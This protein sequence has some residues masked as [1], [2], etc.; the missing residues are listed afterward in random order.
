MPEA[1][2]FEA[3]NAGQVSVVTGHIDRFEADGIRMVDGRLVEADLVAAATGFNMN[4]MGDID[5]DIDGEPVD[6]HETITYRGMMFTGVPNL[7]WVFGYFR[8]SWTLRSELVAEF[9]CRLLEHMERH[10]HGRVAPTLRPHQREL[11]PTGWMDKADFNPAY[12]ERAEPLLPQRL[13]DREW[14]HTQDYWREKDDF[15]AIDLDDE[16]F[17]Y[18]LSRARSQVSRRTWA[19]NSIGSSIERR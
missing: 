12:L 5:F 8:A 19:P 3:V 15:P 9:V 10:G 7:A 14:Q 6:F 11:Q 4:I 1:D 18:A 2:L 17:T 13:E 16:I